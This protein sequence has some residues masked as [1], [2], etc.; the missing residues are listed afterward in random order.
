V[1][2][3]VMIANES[4]WLACPDPRP[5]LEFL[6]DRDDASPR[7]LN[8]Y[9]CACCRRLWPMLADERC[10]NAIAFLEKWT[11]KM[12]GTA[13]IT[14]TAAHYATWQSA[15][16]AAT[17]AKNGNQPIAYATAA[18]LNAMEEAVTSAAC[19]SALALSHAGDADS[20]AN[21]CNELAGLLRHIVGNPFRPVAASCDW[22]GAVIHVAEACYAGQ[23]KTAALRDALCQAGQAELAEHFSKPGHPKGCWAL[24]LILG[25]N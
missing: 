2:E 8:L 11:E 25:K 1:V 7:K 12:A 6:T 22:T 10:R 14:M 21:A 3:K 15:R 5:M 16:K 17:D 19:N 20:Y 23:E 9:A 24:D 4:E 18:V 13:R